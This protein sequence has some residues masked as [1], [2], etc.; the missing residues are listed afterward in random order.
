M[1]AFSLL[2]RS[3]SSSTDTSTEQ[4]PRHAYSSP[5]IYQ[6][7]LSTKTSE[8]CLN[9]IT[10]QVE[11]LAKPVFAFDAPAI[12]SAFEVNFKDKSAAVV[13]VIFPFT[14]PNRELLLLAVSESGST[15]KNCL[16][17]EVNQNRLIGKGFQD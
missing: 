7:K 12:C 14:E 3:T 6:V 15:Y 8:G 16:Q 5:R 17:D 10:K 13:P 11:L 1:S 9:E 2:Q 4:N